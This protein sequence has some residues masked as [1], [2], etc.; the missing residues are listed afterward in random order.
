MGQCCC[1]KTQISPEDEEKPEA[2]PKEE[3]RLTLPSL[4]GVVPQD[5]PYTLGGQLVPTEP[6]SPRSGL[7]LTQ[8]RE[9]LSGYFRDLPNDTT[10]NRFLRARQ[11]NLEPAA[12]MYVKHRHWRQSFGAD[13]IIWDF[14]FHEREKVLAVYPTGYHRTGRLGHPVY[15]ERLGL[16]DVEALLDITTIDR[17][18]RAHVQAYEKMVQHKFP[19]CALAQ[20]KPISQT[21]TIMD[22]EGISMGFFFSNK[23]KSILKKVIGLD[24]D[25]YPECLYKMFLVNAPWAFTAAYS[26]FKGFFDPNTLD[27]IKVLGSDYMDEL[28]QH[29]DPCNLP[30]FLGGKCKCKG[31]CLHVQPGPWEDY[32]MVARKEATGWVN[33][34]DFPEASPEVEEEEE[35]ETEWA[36]LAVG[37]A[38]KLGSVG[39]ICFRRRNNNRQGIFKVIPKSEGVFEQSDSWGSVYTKKTMPKRLPGVKARSKLPALDL[40]PC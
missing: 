20:K 12:E 24:S 26:V 30:T 38:K 5:H 40:P 1:S 14:D 34:Y 6:L 15:I 29:I 11:R 35:E 16:L 18:L 36:P 17:Y 2:L 28:E 39:L 7:L 27:K 37:T 9:K 10:L 21:I 4:L 25:N 22:L 3:K 32:P 8:F 19:S 23:N 13:T 31:G 33:D